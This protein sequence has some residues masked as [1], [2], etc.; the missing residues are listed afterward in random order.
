MNSLKYFITIACYEQARC[1]LIHITYG[2]TSMRCF[3][4]R[5]VESIRRR[6]AARF[7]NRLEGGRREYFWVGYAIGWAF[8]ALSPAM[9][10]LVLEELWRRIEK[11][12]DASFDLILAWLKMLHDAEDPRAT[13]DKMEEIVLRHH[14]K[15]SRLVWDLEKIET[16]FGHRNI[17]ESILRIA[18][19]F[20]EDVLCIRGWGHPVPADIIQEHAR[21][22][23]ELG[24][25][26]ELGT[27][28]GPRVPDELLHT[29]MRAALKRD[30]TVALECARELKDYKVMAEILSL[31]GTPHEMLTAQLFLKSLVPQDHLPH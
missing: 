11:L 10:I 8:A 16:L 9:R 21:D 19:E 13:R 20:R 5:F 26:K 29:C 22:V 12:G 3:C 6:K 31:I 23:A 14:E 15:T 1:L 24:M 28:C 4:S 17:P 25:R 18:C 2:R 30:L 27:L 7:V